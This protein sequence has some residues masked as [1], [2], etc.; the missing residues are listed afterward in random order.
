MPAGR[1]ACRVK[2]ALPAAN[3]SALDR[4]V[5]EGQVEQRFPR[6]SRCFGRSLEIGTASTW[7]ATEAQN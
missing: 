1:L 6:R 3:G 2:K 5:P 4:G 7:P